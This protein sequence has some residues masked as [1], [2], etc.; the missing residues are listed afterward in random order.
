M[1]AA[2]FIAQGVSTPGARD[3]LLT[4]IGPILTDGNSN[5][6]CVDRPDTDNGFVNCPAD[7]SHSFANLTIPE[8]QVGSSKFNY[9]DFRV[10]LEHD[11]SKDTMTYGKV[12]TGHKAGGFNDSFQATGSLIPE[13]F[14]PESLVVY[15]VGMRHAFNLGGRRAIFNASGF[16]YDY[17]DQVFQ[18]LTCIAFDN[19]TATPRCTGYSLV[20]RNVGASQVTGLELEAQL[21][22]G[23]SFKLDL[24]ASYLRTKITK[25]VLADFRAQDFDQP[26][27]VDGVVYGNGRTPAIS[28]VG[29]K[30]P[31]ASTL[32][33]AARLQQILLIGPGRFDWQV[34]ANYRSSYYLTPFNELP[35]DYL[36]PGK[37][38]QTAVQAGFPDRQKGFT[39]L[40]IGF[41]YEFASLRLEAF[42]NNVTN[43]QVSQKAI[44]GNGVNV[45]FLND[46][47]TYGLRGR[48]VF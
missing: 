11:L 9:T 42:G 37:A 24:N 19:T 23:N 10:G 47:R 8:Q 38:D 17:K 15:E 44:V 43:E 34:L 20:N 33:L 22:L 13:T 5:G 1:Q 36:R 48:Y 25:G 28:V 18:D 41:G 2:Q 40:N 21:P 16:H 14:K 6:T 29:N 45:R 3:T 46:A 27:E 7:G 35:V 39:T 32:N 26:P 31:L 4:Q 12:S 30:L